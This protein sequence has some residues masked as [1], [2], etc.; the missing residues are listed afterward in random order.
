MTNAMPKI[1]DSGIQLEIIRDF[2]GPLETV[3]DAW[4]NAEA[5][6]LWMGPNTAKC[7]KATANPVM[8]GEYCF[9]ME[10]ENGNVSTVV[11][12]YTQIER[13]FR[14]AF[15]WSWLQEDK[16]IGQP[17]HVSLEFERLDT[18]RT[19]M[20]MLHVNFLDESSKSSHNEGWI[21][22][23]NCLDTFLNKK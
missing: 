1:E 9:P 7:P 16:T 14:L 21:G 8:N 3:F 13:P 6:R 20:K 15:S 5:L 18:N 19:R 2:E 23:F 4:T 17:M 12:H 10:M 22:C 11:G